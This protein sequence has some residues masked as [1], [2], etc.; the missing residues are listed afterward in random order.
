MKKELL[1]LPYV[2]AVLDDCLKLFDANC[3]EYFAPNERDDYK[4]FLEAS[5]D[6]YE[7]CFISGKLIAAFGVFPEETAISGGAFAARAASLNWILINPDMQGS[8]IGTEL[9]SRAL[10]RARLLGAQTLK[11]AASHKS[12]P[13]FKKFAAKTVCEKQDGW[14]PDMHRIDM[15][16]EL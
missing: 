1:Y 7:L 5:P 9:M 15:V 13:F 6:A 2:S 10:S 16:I 4:S 11:I 8:G 12:A 3:P 14:G